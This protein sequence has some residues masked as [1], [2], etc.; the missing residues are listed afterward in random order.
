MQVPTEDMLAQ[1]ES[2][3]RAEFPDVRLEFAS[4]SFTK[5][6]EL[7]V[8][9]LN[10]NEYERVRGACRRISDEQKLEQHEPEIWL[11][12]KTWTGPWPGGESEQ[13]IKR[14]REDFVRR[15]NLSLRR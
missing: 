5:T 2:D 4:Q 12:A 13:E 14:R 9:V 10:L 15:H 6:V 11:M 3:L 8:Y 1:I 7:W